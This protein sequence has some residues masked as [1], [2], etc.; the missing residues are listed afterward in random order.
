MIDINVSRILKEKLYEEVLPIYFSSGD[1]HF[2]W[3]RNWHIY[4]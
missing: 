2:I 4:D 3:N 1:I